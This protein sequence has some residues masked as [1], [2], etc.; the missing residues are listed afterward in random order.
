MHV[1]VRSVDL[2]LGALQW[3]LVDSR[4]CSFVNLKV[5]LEGMKRWRIG[6]GSTGAGMYAKKRLL[7]VGE[8]RLE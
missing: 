4:A 7:T 8:A 6:T 5:L 1:Q 3:S 2:F